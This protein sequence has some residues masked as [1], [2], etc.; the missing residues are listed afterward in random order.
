M[1]KKGEYAVNSY[2]N[3][4]KR[5]RRGGRCID[6]M[7]SAYHM[8]TYAMPQILSLVKGKDAEREEQDKEK[9]FCIHIIL[10]II[11]TILFI[12]YF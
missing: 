7:A 5:E 4:T 9:N 11:T 6:E 12:Q 1:E 10:E 3:M 2:E 8:V